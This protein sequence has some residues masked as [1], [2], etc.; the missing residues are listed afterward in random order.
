[1]ADTDYNSQV[2][3]THLIANHAHLDSIPPQFI[4]TLFTTTQHR[5]QC[6]CCV[7]VPADTNPLFMFCLVF[8]SDLVLTFLLLPI[9]LFA[10]CLFL[11]HIYAS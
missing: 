10:H 4:R 2:T 5:V 3:H 7:Y 11:D 9:L 8:D 1:M 6:M